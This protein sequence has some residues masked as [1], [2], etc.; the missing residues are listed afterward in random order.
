MAD[1]ISPHPKHKFPWPMNS[2]N[3]MEGICNVHLV[4]A[5]NCS[6]QENTAH[7]KRETLMDLSRSRRSKVFPSVLTV[8]LLKLAAR[9][10]R[11]TLENPLVLYVTHVKKIITLRAL[12]FVCN[13]LTAD[14]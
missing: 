9:H 13:A 7:L 8:M 4:K 3:P 6:T 14:I 5:M 12:A 11:D 2:C 1:A 10:V